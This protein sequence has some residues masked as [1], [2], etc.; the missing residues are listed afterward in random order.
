VIVH[1]PVDVCIVGLGAAGGTI[2]AGLVK[3][4][5][6]VVALEAGPSFDPTTSPSEFT[7]DEIAHIV[8]RR[9]LWSEP[10]VLMLDDGPPIVRSWL[11][12][13]RGVGGPH[14]WSGFAY[15]FHPSDF[16]VASGSGT[17]DGTSVTDWPIGYEDL[18]PWY[19]QAE[20]VMGV[21]GLAGE[22]PFEAP[23]RG[24]YPN[25]PRAA[26]SASGLLSDAARRLG[27][28]PYHPPS[29]ILAE[30]QGQRLPCNYCGHCTFYGCHTN[31]RFST[32]VTI[33][34]NALS[35]GLVQIRAQS[36]ATEVVSDRGGH[37]RAVR[38]VT[39]DGDAHEQPARVI[40]LALNSPY[41]ARL[42]LLSRSPKHP[43]GL[44]NATDQVGRHLT[45]HT[46]A[47]AYGVYDDPLHAD[48]GPAQHI[49]IEDFNESRPAAAGE[50]F[51]RGGVLH[52]G[53]PAA[54]TGGPLAFARSLDD[55]IPLPQ[56]V[57]RY[58]DGL[59]EFAAHAYSRHQAVYALGE[60]L[61]QAVNRASLDPKVRD[62][63]GF[64]ALRITYRP[65]PEDVAQQRFLLARSVELL[66]SSS[67]RQVV[68]A[69]SRIPGGMFAGH[70]HGTTRMGRDPSQSVANDV[71][72]VHGT[73]NLFVAGAG[74]FVTSAGLN[75]AL[76]VVALALRAV[77]D[78]AAAGR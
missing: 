52:G 29:A 71:G 46:G 7:D 1:D 3:K 60:D 65:H 61:P 41:V 68:E 32:L 78:I 35:S 75:P 54:F 4:G 9:M 17:P 18:E 45:F 43:D 56:D 47:F 76:T 55:T 73:E 36:T 33:L 13:N 77:D 66:H 40:V 49:G 31:A 38:Y 67:A 59:L 44:G 28:H 51:L 25:P 12:R 26:S 23:R 24:P 63:L 8:D 39:D 5:L 42:L 37:P 34:P 70:A 48:R 50:R 16:R 22:D 72:L 27:W 30:R 57:P 62:S 21:G 69:P 53:M 19:E 15:R 64:P 10:E 14:A 74:L 20:T 6:R 58:G 2:A 11:A